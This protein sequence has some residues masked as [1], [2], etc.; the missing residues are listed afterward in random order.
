M[1]GKLKKIIGTIVAV[2]CM[3]IMCVPVQAYAKSAPKLS[4]DQYSW[5]K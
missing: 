2:A 4:V 5:Q 3:C 1:N